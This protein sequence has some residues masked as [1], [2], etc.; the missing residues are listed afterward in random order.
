MVP[1]HLLTLELDQGRLHAPNQVLHLEKGHL[2]ARHIHA[3]EHDRHARDV[4]T[5]GWW[6]GS[7]EDARCEDD[8]V[9]A[10]M[11]YGTM[12]TMRNWK[13]VAR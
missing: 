4:A 10:K 5:H 1:Q 3:V 12:Q 11:G 2:N 8:L 6:S 9:W 13:H 7:E